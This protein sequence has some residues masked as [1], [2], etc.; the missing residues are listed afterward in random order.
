MSCIH[1]FRK[2]TILWGIAFLISLHV[3]A[4]ETLETRVAA[5]EKR[6]SGRIGVS[7]YDTGKDKRIEYRPNERFLMCSTFK[8]LA[9]AAVLRS[10]DEGK[11]DLSR[12]VH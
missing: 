8:F 2:F 1:S 9:A 11:D 7:V 10:V 4:A 3:A 5:I 6:T 12:F